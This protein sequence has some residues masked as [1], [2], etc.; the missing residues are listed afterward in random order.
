MY[1][2]VEEKLEEYAITDLYYVCICKNGSF[3]DEPAHVVSFIYVAWRGTDVELSKLS[4][5]P[6]VEKMQTSNWIISPTF[7]MKIQKYLSCHHPARLPEKHLRFGG[8]TGGPPKTY[9]PN[10]Q[11]A[12]GIRVEYEGDA[13]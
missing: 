13:S 2:Q 10:N 3:Q 6:Y 9:H 1:L 8:M 7:G 4:M 12:G 5:A 11:T